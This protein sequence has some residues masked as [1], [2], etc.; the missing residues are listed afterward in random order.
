M[1]QRGSV[2][3]GTLGSRVGCIT[4]I[5]YWRPSEVCASICDKVIQVGMRR[6]MTNQ[7]GEYS[8]HSEVNTTFQAAINI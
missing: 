7:S 4:V 1:A 5:V 8:L 3:S 6:S 2:A